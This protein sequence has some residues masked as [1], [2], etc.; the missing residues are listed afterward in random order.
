MHELPATR[1]TTAPGATAAVAHHGGGHA[2]DCGN[3]DTPLTGPF[4]AQCGQHAHESARNLSAVVHN[5]WHDLT[6]LDGRLWP[7]VYRLLLKPGQLTV[8]YFAER[9]ARYLP[10]VRL[11]LVL[12]L[13]F[14]ALSGLGKVHVGPTEGEGAPAAGPPADIAAEIAAGA[15]KV[16]V[17]RN[18]G[19]GAP[20]VETA[21]GVAQGGTLDIGR[22][23]DDV[24]IG[25]IRSLTRAARA[26]CMK[27][28][29][30]PPAEFIRALLHNVPKMMFVFLPLMA[31]LMALLYW[32]PRRYYVEH[33]VFL[34]H[35]HSALYLWFVLLELV[36]AAAN[37]WPPLSR[38]AMLLGVGTAA[39][40][41]LYPYLAQRRYYAQ[42]RLLTLVKYALLALAY[43]V[44]LVLTLLGTAALTAYEG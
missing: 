24:D 37:L 8:D 1:R 38:V 23:C 20:A 34:L 14:F 16:H 36:G 31:G 39:Y 7:T 41:P 21:D 6:H 27:I 5:A 30:Q 42:S 2:T 29:A 40:V 33:L 26:A 18:E 43:L 32:R 19:E 12:S 15:A 4:C 22:G 28:G 44:C 3:C 17:D 9:R 11:Y 13:A 25:G 10:P 35:N